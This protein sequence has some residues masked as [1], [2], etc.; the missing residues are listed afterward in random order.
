MRYYF[1]LIGLVAGPAQAHHE[2]VV[3]TSFLPVMG[4][5]ALIMVAG[6]AAARQKLRSAFLRHVLLAKWAGRSPN[7]P[8]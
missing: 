4:G 2:V 7:Q 1:V 3:A 6:L 5:L 8:N